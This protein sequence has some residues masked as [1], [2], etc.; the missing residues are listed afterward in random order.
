[1]KT[2]ATLLLTLSAVPAVGLAASPGDA[3]IQ[4]TAPTAHEAFAKS[5]NRA[6]D[7][8]LT[9]SL[10]LL[11]SSNAFER[12]FVTV[13]F[14]AD[15]MGRPN[16]AEV[17]RASGSRRFDNLALRSVRR[18]N[19]G[20]LPSGV[21]VNQTVLAHIIVSSDQRQ[22]ESYRSEIARAARWSPLLAGGDAIVVSVVSPG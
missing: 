19:I 13:R 21:A 4:V 7:R 8:W 10:R 22:I 1:M 5:V 18:M 9:R 15:A 2:A 11:A 17:L 20:P 16:S 14:K 12:G 3:N 6:L